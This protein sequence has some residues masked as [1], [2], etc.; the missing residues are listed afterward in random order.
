MNTDPSS[1]SSCGLALP[2]NV[3]Q[4]LC[5][6]CLMAGAMETLP[7]TATASGQENTEE[8]RTAFPQLDILKWFGAGGMGRVFK[9]RQPSLDRLVALKILPPEQS[10]DPE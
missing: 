9:A 6:R 4:G 2:E 5:P 3:P 8:L 7:P 1:C 10:R